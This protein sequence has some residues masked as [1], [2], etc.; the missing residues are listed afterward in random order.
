MLG[1]AALLA[2]VGLAA[3]WLPAH[4]AAS[5]DPVNVLRDE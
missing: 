3:V 5:V 2:I 1:A 4:R